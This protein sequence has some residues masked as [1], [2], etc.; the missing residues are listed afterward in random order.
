[1]YEAIGG[2]GNEDTGGGESYEGLAELAVDEELGPFIRE[3]EEVFL[4]EDPP[5]LSVPD[6]FIDCVFA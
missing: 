6:C 3:G 1:M 2:E 5:I 4:D